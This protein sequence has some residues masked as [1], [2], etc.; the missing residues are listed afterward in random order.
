MHD[1]IGSIVHYSTI[2]Y[3]RVVSCTSLASR[4]RVGREG[5]MYVLCWVRNN[6]G[7]VGSILNRDIVVNVER[8]PIVVS[9]YLHTYPT[10]VLYWYTAK[11]LTPCMNMF[12]L[13]PK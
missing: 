10:S 11:Y 9:F 8:L 2:Q 13:R 4:E 1:K 3:L 6:F 7:I 5:M 12:H